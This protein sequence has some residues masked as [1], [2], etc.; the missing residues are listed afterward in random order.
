VETPAQARLL[1]P[2]ASGTW[3]A[4]PIAGRARALG[5]AGV[6]LEQELLELRA[7]LSACFTSEGQSRHL[8]RPVAQVAAPA[9]DDTGSTV[10]VLQVEAQRGELRILGAPVE[11][12]SGATDATLACVQDTLHDVRVASAATPPGPRFRLRFTVAP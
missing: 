8:G 5:R 11:V 12:R 4:T 2:P 7:P 1:A 9:I 3:E 10:V 6:D